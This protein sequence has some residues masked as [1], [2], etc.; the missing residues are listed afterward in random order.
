MKFWLDVNASPLF[1]LICDPLNIG[2]LVKCK[3]TK[4]FT[5]PTALIKY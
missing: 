2:F 4:V 1:K 5:D 3:V